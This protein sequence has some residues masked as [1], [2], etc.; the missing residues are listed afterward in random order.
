MGPVPRVAKGVRGASRRFRGEKKYSC[1]FMGMFEAPMATSIIVYQFYVLWPNQ[2][3][4]RECLLPRHVDLR[5]S[6]LTLVRQE[7]QRRQVHCG[8]HVRSVF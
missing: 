1:H 3:V 6:S 8:A 5:R 4:Q 7:R 2:M